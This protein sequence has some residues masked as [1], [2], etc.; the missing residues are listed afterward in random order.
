MSDTVVQECGFLLEVTR[1]TPAPVAESYA[2]ESL[3]DL[4]EALEGVAEEATVVI[5]LAC[6]DGAGGAFFVFLSEGRACIHLT[7]GAC[8]TARECPPLPDDQIICFRMDNGE[9]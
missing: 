5:A 6:D 3:E 4:E 1:F 9:S 7:E 8:W 2:I